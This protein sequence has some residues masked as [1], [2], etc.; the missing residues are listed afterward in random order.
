LVSV[1]VVVADGILPAI[2]VFGIGG[3]W[4][5]GAAMQIVAG[6][7]TRMRGR[8]HGLQHVPLSG[9]GRPLG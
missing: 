8:D 2:W 3:L 4:F 6:V 5:A 9:T 7:T 1:Y